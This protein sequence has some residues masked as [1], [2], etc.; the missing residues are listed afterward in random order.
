[1]SMKSADS[2]SRVWLVNWVG[3]TAA[4]EHSDFHLEAVVGTAAEAQRV[5]RRI[6]DQWNR[7]LAA[8]C[9]R[10]KHVDAFVRVDVFTSE[11]VIGGSRQQRRTA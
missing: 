1:M 10:P 3:W 11:W 9:D 4:G 6:K 7:R 2:G 8:P 5:R